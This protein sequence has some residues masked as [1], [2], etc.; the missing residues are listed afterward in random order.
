[1]GSGIRSSGRALASLEQ[2][3]DRSA[4]S[5]PIGGRSST[6]DFIADVEVSVG[7]SCTSQLRDG[8]SR[9]FPASG[10]PVLGCEQTSDGYQIAIRSSPLCRIA[11]PRLAVE[12][13]REGR[14]V[15]R[16]TVCAHEVRG[17]RI[18]R[19]EDLGLLR[20]ELRAERG[21]P[22]REESAGRGSALSIFRSG[23][24]A[25]ARC[26][27]IVGDA[28]S[29]EIGDILAE[30]QVAIDLEARAAAT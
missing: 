4:S 1:M 26:T 30:R 17:V 11:S 23:L 15:L 18:G 12:R 29:A 3:L 27:R 28:Q 9:D 16:R 14:H 20:R 6:S 5:A 8:P 21:R 25:V 10:A 13:G 22:A 2:R 19:H 7:A 24:P